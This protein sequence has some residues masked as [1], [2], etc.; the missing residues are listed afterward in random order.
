MS[1]NRRKIEKCLAGE[2]NHVTVHMGVNSNKIIH[3]S[4]RNRVESCWSVVL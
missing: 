2:E 1:N 4:H 3:L